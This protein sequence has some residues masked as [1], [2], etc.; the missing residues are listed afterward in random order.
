MEKENILRFIKQE[1]ESDYL[2]FKAKDYPKREK[3]RFFKR[4]N[5]Y[6]KL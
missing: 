2:D 4:Y 5:I 6:G 1:N 3:D